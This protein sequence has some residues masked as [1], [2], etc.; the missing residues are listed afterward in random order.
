[1]SA[2]YGVRFVDFKQFINYCRDLNVTVNERELEHYEKT[3]VMLPT[4][5]VTYPD[6]YVIQ[7][8]QLAR[9]VV[10]VEQA[11]GQWPELERLFEKPRFLQEDY[12]NLTD[13]EFQELL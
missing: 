3:R 10:N 13:D 1:M 9:V 12:D 5:R 6:A 2:Q 8:A 7:S 11:S 4:A